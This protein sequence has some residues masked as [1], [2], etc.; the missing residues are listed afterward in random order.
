LSGAGHWSII[1]RHLIPNTLGLIIVYTSLTVPTVILQESFLAFIG[2]AVQYNGEN[3]DS[4]GALVKSGVDSL[5]YTSGGRSWLLIWPSV[6]MSATLVALN[7]L[8]DGLRDALD[9][10]LKGRTS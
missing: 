6:V 10:Q 7:V 9:P 5:D 3:L 4:W 1:T 2:L 8:G